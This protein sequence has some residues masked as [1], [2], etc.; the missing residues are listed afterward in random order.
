MARSRNESA[1]KVAAQVLLEV[2]SRRWSLGSYALQEEN[3]WRTWASIVLLE[4]GQNCTRAATSLGVTPQEGTK[5]SAESHAT[6][7]LSIW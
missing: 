6:V 7:L 1:A 2:G 3:S 5:G 4:N